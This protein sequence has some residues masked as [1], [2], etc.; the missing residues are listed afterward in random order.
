MVLWIVVGWWRY[1]FGQKWKRAPG[2]IGSTHCFCASE[3][4]N[5]WFRFI[6]CDKVRVQNIWER[7]EKPK[8]TTWGMREVQVPHGDE[9]HQP[10]NSL[11]SWLRTTTA[12]AWSGFLFL[13]LEAFLVFQ[14]YSEENHQSFCAFFA[15]FWNGSKKG[16]SKRNNKNCLKRATGWLLNLRKVSSNISRRQWV[17]QRRLSNARGLKKP[18]FFSSFSAFLDISGYVL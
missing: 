18:S 8:L 5:H 14:T 11:K 2:A 6:W 16:G 12:L 10:I 7:W 9:W 3:F 17:V 4:V 1:L 13:I 15:W